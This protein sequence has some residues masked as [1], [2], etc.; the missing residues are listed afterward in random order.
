MPIAQSTILKSVRSGVIVL[1][2][3]DRIVHFNPVAREILGEYSEKALGKPI[4][5]FLLDWAQWTMEHSKEETYRQE[6]NLQEKDYELQLSPMYDWRQ[7]L[8]GRLVMLEDISKRKL[9][10]ST[11]KESEGRYRGVV[12]FLPE[13]IAMHKDGKL[14]SQILLTVD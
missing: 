12:D 9:A 10:E 5:L 11:L 3:E 6:I 8:I 2:R 13:G 7:V 1:D 4:T 14:S